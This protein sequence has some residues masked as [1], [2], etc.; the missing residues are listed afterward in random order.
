MGV[1]MDLRIRDETKGRQG[2]ARIELTQGNSYVSK[3][4]SLQLGSIKA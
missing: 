1:L 4:G 3:I 2:K